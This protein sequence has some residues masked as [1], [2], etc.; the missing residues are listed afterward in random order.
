[1]KVKPILRWI[2]ADL[3]SPEQARAYSSMPLSVL[4]GLH[5]NRQIKV[6]RLHGVPKVSRDSIDRLLHAAILTGKPIYYGNPLTRQMQTIPQPEPDAPPST[7]ACGPHRGASDQPGSTPKEPVKIIHFD[8][9]FSSSAGVQ[10][11]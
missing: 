9:Y 4:N 10:V 7:S 2:H 8:A 1:M 11:Q 6:V 5:N 3:V